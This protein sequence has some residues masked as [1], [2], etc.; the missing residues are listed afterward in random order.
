MFQI[1][2]T[3]REKIRVTLVGAGT[4]AS[5]RM[6]LDDDPNRVP[7]PDWPYVALED[8]GENKEDTEGWEVKDKIFRVRL[9]VGVRKTTSE[10]ALEDILANRW[11]PLEAF[12]LQEYQL[13]EAGVA[14]T[15]DL[16]FD[17]VTAGYFEDNPAW[18]FREGV[19]SYKILTFEEK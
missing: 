4:F 8:D 6:G 2:D 13:I 7:L 1:I 3:L 5:V 11:D 19:L 12:I 16:G 15:D 14:L 10:Q 17:E 9:E 18:R